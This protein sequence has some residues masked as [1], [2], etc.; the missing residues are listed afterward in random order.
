MEPRSTGTTME[1]DK[2]PRFVEG[3][4]GAVGAALGLAFILL[5]L[6]LFTGGVSYRKDCLNAEGR[7]TQSW[8]FTWFAP[9]PYLFRPSDPD[10][11]VHTGTRVALNAIGI[12][13]YSDT[14][15]TKIAE[16]AVESA[17]PDAETA[18]WVK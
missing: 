12:A 8:T 14:N 11:V 15:S 13:P 3:V 17:N 7:V 9:L 6:G 5:Q 16:A 10:C 1:R 2:L 18:Y 4:A